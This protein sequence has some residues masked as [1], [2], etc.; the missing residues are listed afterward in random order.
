MVTAKDHSPA[1]ITVPVIRPTRPSVSDEYASSNGESIDQNVSFRTDSENWGT[2]RGGNRMLASYTKIPHTGSTD[3]HGQA[4]PAALASAGA[5]V[6]EDMTTTLEPAEIRTMMKEHSTELMRKHGE[7][8]YKTKALK[9]YLRPAYI[10]TALERDADGRLYLEQSVLDK[11]CPLWRIILA[12]EGNM[13]RFDDGKPPLHPPEP[14]HGK[15]I[16]GRVLEKQDY[17]QDDLSGIVKELSLDMKEIRGV[18]KEMR[19]FK[20][21]LF[22]EATPT[23]SEIDRS[24]AV[25][26]E[27]I[28]PP[29]E[30]E[31][32]RSRRNSADSSGPENNDDH[33]SERVARDSNKIV[34]STAPPEST[35]RNRSSDREEHG[36]PPRPLKGNSKK[37]RDTG[38]THRGG[39]RDSTNNQT[40]P[41]RG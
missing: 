29:P 10:W 9:G 27:L 8:F 17:H 18:L 41:D 38:R 20:A 3:K 19:K 23:S 14:H 7:V 37:R 34:G 26:E 11:Y 6:P 31:A 28:T 4:A 15:S 1:P 2:L 40:L 22:E 39:I 33:A 24:C 32:C 21:H 16:Q 12:Y 36:S 35:K 30:E 25:S 13:K 5:R